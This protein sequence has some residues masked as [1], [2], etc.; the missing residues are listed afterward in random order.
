MWV[1]THSPF[2]APSLLADSAQC[3]GTC[4]SGESGLFLLGF[5]RLPGREDQSQQGDEVP[6]HPHPF[7]AWVFVYRVENKPAAGKKPH[8]ERRAADS[9]DPG[10]TFPS[11]VSTASDPHSTSEIPRARDVA[12][13]T[14]G[15]RRPG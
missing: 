7:S 6:R 10:S 9:F 12:V 5:L 1:R 4:A 13:L 11:Q 14:R 3:R 8:G 2:P 15:R